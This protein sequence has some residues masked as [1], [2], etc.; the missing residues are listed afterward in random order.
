MWNGMGFGGWGW[1]GG[2]GLGMVLFW[3]ALI[4]VIV[5]VVRALGNDAATKGGDKT[6]LQILKER[7]ARGE[8]GKDEFE[9][10]QRDLET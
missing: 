7:Y 1:G 8:I 10:K 5:L 2:M 9:Q 3:G 6:P 4:A